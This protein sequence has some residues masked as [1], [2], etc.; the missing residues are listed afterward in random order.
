[1]VRIFGIL[2]TNQS[3]RLFKLHPKEPGENMWT[4]FIWLRK[5]RHVAALQEHGDWL[6]VFLN[7]KGFPKI[8][9]A[10][11]SFSRQTNVLH[12]AEHAAYNALK[13]TTLPQKQKQ[14]KKR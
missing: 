14:V 8:I 4:R 7:Y 5:G 10:T 13:N 2:A 1:M 12:G 6:S 11:V 9:C 3:E